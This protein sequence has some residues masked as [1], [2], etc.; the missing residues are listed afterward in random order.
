MLLGYHTS[1]YLPLKEHNA[2]K[3]MLNDKKKKKVKKDPNRKAREET[4]CYLN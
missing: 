4:N 1:C 2:N 3:E